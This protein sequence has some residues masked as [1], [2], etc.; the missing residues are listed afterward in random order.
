[1]NK[2]NI[3]YHTT[4]LL[5]ESIDF[6]QIKKD[7]W[8]VDATLGGGGHTERI[9]ELGGKVISFDQDSDSIEYVT[10]KLS[11]YSDRL[12]IIHDNFV[13]MNQYLDKFRI[14]PKGIIFDL[15]V[16][17]YQLDGHNRGFSFSHDEDLDMRMNPD[18]QMLTAKEIVNTFSVRDIAKIIN[19]YG[20]DRLA[21]KIAN[22]IGTAR[23]KNL[24][25]TTKQLAEII[26]NI[27][28]RKYLSHSK[29]N[30]ATKTFQAL[31]I[32]INN[33]IENLKEAI[34]NS[35]N[36]LSQ[37]GIIAVISFHSLEDKIVKRQF[38]NWEDQNLGKVITK[39][40]ILPS[41]NEIKNN[42]RSRS[43]KLRVFKKH[44]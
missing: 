24:I 30:P 33:E 13:N 38:K 25:R 29:I 31:R 14:N 36:N 3:D 10:K 12:K 22:A 8:F 37:S 34:K 40:P 5:N 11:Q 21:I 7:Q 1:M 39:K 32:F 9:L 44:D 35:I 6:L 18:I 41:E 17:S 42:S 43:S 19:K 16:S 28:S 4:V 20:E 15:G 2:K 26:K 23:K 27:Y